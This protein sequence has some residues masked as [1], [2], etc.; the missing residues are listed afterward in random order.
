M[1]VLNLNSMIYIIVSKKRLWAE[2]VC[3][4]ILSSIFFMVYFFDIIAIK[5]IYFTFNKMVGW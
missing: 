5:V 2:T 4:S 3:Q 1:S